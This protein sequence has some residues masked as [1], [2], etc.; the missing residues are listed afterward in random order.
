MQHR[1]SW[2]LE[3][4]PKMDFYSIRSTTQNIF[5]IKKVKYYIGKVVPLIFI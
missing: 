1:K 2:Y 3:I 5:D 4:Q